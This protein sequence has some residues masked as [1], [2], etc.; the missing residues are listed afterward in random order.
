LGSVASNTNHAYIAVN[1]EAIDVETSEVVASKQVDGKVTDVNITGALGAHTGL[2][3]VGSWDQYPRG[4]ALQKVVDKAVAFLASELP[5]HY[6]TDPPE[7]KPQL[8]ADKVA[9]KMQGI[10]K[11]LGYYNGTVDGMLGAQSYEA[12]KKFQHDYGLNVTGALDP[13]TREKLSSLAE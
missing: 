11:N 8:A 12:I 2:G 3:D 1:L 13:P 4:K 9:M 5:E 10:L 7:R 6:F